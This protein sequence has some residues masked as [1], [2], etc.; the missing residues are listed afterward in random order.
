METKSYEEETNSGEHHELQSASPHSGKEQDL[1]EL[2]THAS[3]ENFVTTKTWVVV[4]A[5]S[6]SYAASFWPVPFFSQIQSEM[7]VS[8]GSTSSEGPW[9]TSVF[10]TAATIAFMICGANSDLF[11]RRHFILG[12]QILVF[13]GAI[14]G[15]TSHSIAQTIAAHVILGFGSGNCQLAAFA[16]PELLPNR[17]RHIGVVIADTVTFFDVIGGP[18]T[19]RV[20][21]AHGDAVR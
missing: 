18:V 12:G 9:L 13:V 11:G 8:L 2:S 1:E 5:M 17:W 19:A 15:G 21:L 16:I 4:W 6:L 20:A 14:V 10:I 3:Q 7:A